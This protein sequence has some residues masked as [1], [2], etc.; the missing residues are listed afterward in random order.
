MRVL[1][2]HPAFAALWLAGL[3]SGAAG[4]ALGFALTVRVFELTESATASAALIIGILA[5]QALLGGVVGALA[6]RVDRVQ[7]IRLMCAM[8]IV[9][10]VGLVLAAESFAATL[11]LAAVN[12]IATQA[13]AAA[14]Q[15]TVADLVPRD[16]LPEAAG[17]NSFAYNATR[18]ASPALGGVLMTA[19]GYRW[20]LLV[21]A[22]LLLL[23]IG[24]LLAVP[25][26]GSYP[27]GTR[28][29]IPALAIRELVASP[30]IRTVTAVQ[31]LDSIKEG[32]LSALFPILMLQVIGAS[33][34]FMGIV[35]SSFAISAI[36]AGPVTATL[37]RRLG[38]RPLVAGGTA[39]SGALL[40]LLAL[41]PSEATALISFA[42]AGL[43]FTLSWAAMSALVLLNVRKESLGRVIGG[44]SGITAG[45]TAGSALASGVLAEIFGPLPVLV[46][47]ASVQVLAGAAAQLGLPA[48]SEPA[49]EP[50]S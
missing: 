41:A 14:E 16:E 6:D 30:T 18:L 38:A 22:A 40:L 44:L 9:V 24:A 28:P 23:T 36:V 1:R 47:A 10:V 5:P 49:P 21:V 32:A 4:W 48:R 26:Q 43:P 42:G 37:M 2:S 13:A 39:L 20:T 7:L 25:R 12:A 3:G 15:A 8:R 45:V 29:A 34:A 35:N 19:F 50:E 11:V 31:V 46:V 17:M 33:E 27:R